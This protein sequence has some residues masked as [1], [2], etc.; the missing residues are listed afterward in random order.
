MGAYSR[1]GRLFEGA[2]VRGITVGKESSWEIGVVLRYE[3]FQQKSFFECLLL[4][5][6]DK[7]SPK[8]LALKIANENESRHLVFPGPGVSQLFGQ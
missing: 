8:S 1:G 7:K 2:L 5:N 6:I 3:Q 4:D